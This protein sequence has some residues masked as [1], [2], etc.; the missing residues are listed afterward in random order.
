MTGEQRWAATGVVV[1]L[2]VLWA[3]VGA[4]TI[5][6]PYRW[7]PPSDDTT[8]FYVFLIGL[9]VLGCA[10]AWLLVGL[11]AVRRIASGGWAWRPVALLS[12]LAGALSMLAAG[13]TWSREDDVAT[14]LFGFQAVALLAYAALLRTPPRPV[15]S[16]AATDA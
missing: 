16:A 1:L 13:A 9:L 2:G 15:D 8:G 5:S 4:W 3:V 11:L 12:A 10:G 14:A 6:E 7:D